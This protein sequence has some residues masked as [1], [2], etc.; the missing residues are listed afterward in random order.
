MRIK[1]HWFKAETAEVA[2]GDRR[3][4]GVHRLARRPELAEDD[5]RGALRAAARPAVLR[6]P[7]RV[8]DLPHAGRRSPRASPAATRR[9][10]SRSPRRWPIASARSSPR[11]SPTCSAR[12]PRATSSAASSTRSTRAR[13]SARASTGPSEGPDYDFLRWLGHRVADGDG[14]ARPDL[15]DLAGH[16]GRGARRRRHAAPRRWPDCSMPRRGRGTERA[17]D[18][19]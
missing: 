9:G 11:T 1:S 8:P 10:A 15:G 4:R 18:R 14:R 7:G 17:C 12:R 3:R 6:L 19:R 16:R 13:R 5:A 2:A